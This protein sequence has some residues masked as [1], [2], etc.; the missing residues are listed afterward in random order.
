MIGPGRAAH[1][2]ARRADRSRDPTMT[3]NNLKNT[4]LIEVIKGAAGLDKVMFDD[5]KAGITV[6]L[7]TGAVIDSFGNKEAISGV[8]IV[9]GTSFADRIT[10][11]NDI[12]YLAGGDGNDT[13]FGGAGHDELYG[14]SGDDSLSGGTGSDFLVGG[15]GND[16][17]SGGVGFDTA[18]YSDEAGEGVSVDLLA[19]FAIDNYGDTDKLSSIER[20]RATDFADK[21][22][23]SDGANLLEG[24]GGDDMLASG[25]GSDTIWAGSGDDTLDG[26]T[27]ADMLTG[28]AGR[29]QIDGGTGT[30]TLDYSLDGGEHGVSVDMQAGM[31]KDTWGDVDAFRNVEN[32]NGTDFADWIAGNTRAN[33]IDGRGGDDKLA[34]GGGKDTFVFGA[35]HGHDRITDFKLDDKLDLRGL[36]VTSLEQALKMAV[37]D[38]GGLRFVTGEDSSILLVNVTV[39]DAVKLGYV[40]A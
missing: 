28:G 16:I 10:G 34:G 32:V 33:V 13:L 21:L 27:G 3:V 11:S 38:N 40:F 17:L 18:D 14:A 5:G 20:V 12:D 30:D 7:A 2:K 24:R 36:G 26:G 37:A 22:T 19:G 9:V 15:R 31:A 39:A 23:G 4:A 25:A 6:N 8:E 29:D 1:R 35:G